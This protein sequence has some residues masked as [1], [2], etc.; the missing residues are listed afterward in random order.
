[1]ASGVLS[2]SAYFTEAE[3]FPESG[4]FHVLGSIKM[5]SCSTG[6]PP[7]EEDLELLILQ[8]LLPHCWDDRSVP[9]FLYDAGNEAWTLCILGKHPTN[10]LSLVLAPTVH[11][12]VKFFDRHRVQSGT[13]LGP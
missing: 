10:Q 6:W 8:P 4:F 9:P 13:V 1:M 7:T 2:P 3:S 12:S 5:V 11:C